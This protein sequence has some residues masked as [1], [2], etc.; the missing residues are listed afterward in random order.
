MKTILTSIFLF[1]AL[2]LSGCTSNEG[3][4][5]KE[6]ELNRVWVLDNLGGK[7]VDNTNFPN[8]APWMEV[9]VGKSEVGGNTGCNGMGGTVNATKD[10]II[11][12]NIIATRMFCDGVDE[13]KF[14][15]ALHSAGAWT[16]ENERLFLYDSYPNGVVLAVFRVKAS[17]TEP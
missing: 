12:G 8:G 16:I 11:F 2:M 6:Y 10:M 17:N 1:T 3:T 14:L 9:N 5:Y 13:Q 4:Y 15:D 7:S